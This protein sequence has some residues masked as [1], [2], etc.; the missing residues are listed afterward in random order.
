M[1]DLDDAFADFLAEVGGDGSMPGS[2]SQSKVEDNA[3]KKQRLPGQCTQAERWM[4]A[5]DLRKT[6]YRGNVEEARKLLHGLDVVDRLLVLEDVDEEDGYT[7]LHLAS[8]QGHINMVELLLQ[9]RADV[10]FPTDDG[11]TAL[12]WAAHRGNA[13][14][15][16][17]LLRFGAESS[18][19]NR[20]CQTAAQQAQAAKHQRL[21]ELLE[22][23]AV[24]VQLGLKRRAV[25]AQKAAAARRAGNAATIAGASNSSE[26]AHGPHQGA[27]HS[28]MAGKKDA[29]RKRLL[30]EVEEEE[31]EAALAELPEFIQPHYRVLGVQA[32][33]TVAEVRRAYRALA[34]KYHPDKNPDDPENATVA[35]RKVALSYE[36]VS[37]YVS[38]QRS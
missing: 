5:E 17:V 1:V 4:W 2:Q 16:K 25:S 31:M 15:C 12:M 9:K 26:Q 28:H 11:D 38:K 10:D 13:Q 18:L 34:L 20:N 27:D 7:A 32:D 14:M 21:F 22:N 37:E 36:A 8:L 33:A 24:D 23:H 35:F 30:E 29:A 3:H 6:A 19:K